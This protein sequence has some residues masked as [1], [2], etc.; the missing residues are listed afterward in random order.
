M[1]R[2]GTPWRPTEIVDDGSD[3]DSNEG[4]S[5]YIVYDHETNAIYEHE[6][7]A[8]F[9]ELV[10]VLEQKGYQDGTPPTAPDVVMEAKEDLVEKE[11]GGN[12]DN[13]TRRTGSSY[14][15]IGRLTSGCTATF[16]GGPQPAGEYF[17]ITAS[18]CLWSSTGAYLDPNFT[19]QQDGASAPWG[20]WDSWQWMMDSFF[21]NNCIGQGSGGASITSA[22]AA[23][24]KVVVRVGRPAS[25]GYPG[26]MGFGAY[27]DSTVNSTS[28]YHRGYAGC[29]AGSPSATLC[30]TRL[31]GDGPFGTVS[32]LGFQVNNWDRLIGHDSDLNGGHSGG[33]LYFYSSGPKVFA[34]QSMHISQ[35]YGSTS[36]SNCPPV[37][38]P[39]QASRIE[40]VFYGWILDFMDSF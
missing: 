16:I 6:T 40:P 10:R 34:V 37:V 2:N 27:S 28:R 39:N 1:D 19:P 33:P 32:W 24:D 36:G 35:C 8:R 21:V 12:T 38:R 22:C 29:G 31:W 4:P 23:R 26:A 15:T 7:A 11:W 5:S 20:V 14:Q 18:H 25:V 17:I 30:N 9:D 13:R 3:P